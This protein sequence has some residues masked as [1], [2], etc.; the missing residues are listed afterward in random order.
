MRVP[1]LRAWC[2]PLLIMAGCGDKAAS[3]ENRSPPRN[4]RPSA[5]PATENVQGS[6][7]DARAGPALVVASGASGEALIVY[8]EFTDSTL[9]DTTVFDP[10]LVRDVPLDLFARRGRVGGGTLTGFRSPAP[11]DECTRWPSAR[12]VPRERKPSAGAWTVGLAQGRAL[13]LTLDSIETLAQQDSARLAADLAR[14]ASALPNDTA[15]SFRGLPFAVRAAW[16]FRL[17]GDAAVVV[18]D[19]VRKVNQEANPRVEHTLVVAEREEGGRLRPAYSERVAGFEETIETTDVLAALLLG[20]QRTPTLVLLRDYGDGST[21][22]FLERRGP[23][24]WRVSWSSAYTG[25]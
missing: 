23:S 4:P 24:T 7:W 14:L 13:P 10:E 8:P 16:R 12:L 25:C 18:A 5:L 11:R 17:P 2:V 15:P 1:R 20:E 3:R 19:L 9:T 6:G 21:F 22:A